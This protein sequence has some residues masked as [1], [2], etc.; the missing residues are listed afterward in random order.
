M[1]YTDEG[2]LQFE[3]SDFVYQITDDNYVPLGKVNEKLCDEQ[4]KWQTVASNNP[5]VGLWDVVEAEY[6]THTARLAGVRPIR[7]DTAEDVLRDFLKVYVFNDKRYGTLE[8][9]KK[10]AHRALEG[11]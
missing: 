9:I 7:K 5:K 4:M 10:R 8:S 6:H 11:K 1:I 2:I 3:E